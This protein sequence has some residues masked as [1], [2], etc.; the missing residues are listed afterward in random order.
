[1]T[2]S[3]PPPIQLS[4]I[5][6]F[7]HEGRTI[8][9]VL[10]DLRATL[11]IPHEI[12][13]IF[14]DP[15]DITLPFINKIQNRDPTLRTIHN[16]LKRGASGALRTGLLESRGQYIL[17]L[18]ADDPSPIHLI[19]QMINLM[20][21]GHDLVSTTRYDLGGINCGGTFP[22]RVLSSCGNR[23]FRFLSHSELSDATSGI[24]MFRK[25][26]LSKID[27]ISSAG[28]TIAF[29]L[30]IKAQSCNFKVA[31]I[32]WRSDNPIKNKRSHFKLIPK[33]FNYGKIFIW[34]V[35]NLHKKS[36]V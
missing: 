14:D 33:I 25:E 16:K 12:L 6:P 34:G 21:R 22:Y 29:E 3:A 1:M 23:M 26:I 10:N 8:A 7:H 28:W 9:P 5:I 13:L 19:N 35:V 2:F 4:I 32:P 15:N 30:A 36:H 17:F 31:E 11:I 24:K 20:E 18:V 27:L